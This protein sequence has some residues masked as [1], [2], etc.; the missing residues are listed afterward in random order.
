MNPTS[1]KF[2]RPL[3]GYGPG[4]GGKKRSQ[5]SYSSSNLDYAL[6]F[7]P[8]FLDIDFS[9]PIFIFSEIPIPLELLAWALKSVSQW[10]E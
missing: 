6:H 4:R 7:A 8:L 10:V 3:P 9:E 5:F 1:L 2:P